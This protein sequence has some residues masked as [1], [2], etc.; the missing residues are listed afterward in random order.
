MILAYDIVMDMAEDEFYALL[1]LRLFVL[2]DSY[3]MIGK[4]RCYRTM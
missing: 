1:Y 2:L 4:G 3:A